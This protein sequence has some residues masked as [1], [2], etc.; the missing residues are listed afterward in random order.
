MLRREL[1]LVKLQR[2]II[3]LEQ[4]VVKSYGINYRNYVQDADQQLY[5]DNTALVNF[6]KRKQQRINTIDNENIV[7]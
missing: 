3:K 7:V 1:R 4:F 2:D 6:C 5:V